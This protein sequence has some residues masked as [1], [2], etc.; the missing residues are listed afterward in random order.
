[1]SIQ[2]RWQVRFTGYVQGVGF[3]ATARSIAG[4]YPITGWVRNEPDGSVVLH[5]QGEPEA[6]RHFISSVQGTMSGMIR[7]VDTIPVDLV[8]G[9]TGFGVAH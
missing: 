8:D 7:N 4:G 1:M 5:A 6:I 9:E 2:V 3:R